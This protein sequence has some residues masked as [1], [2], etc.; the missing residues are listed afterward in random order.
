MIMKKNIVFLFS[1]LLV[2][3]VASSNHCLA[4]D[5]ITVPISSD[6]DINVE[7]FPATGKYLLLWLAPEYGWRPGHRSLSRRLSEQNIEVWLT[8]LLESLFLPQS[9]QAIKQLDG[10]YVADLIEYAHKKTGKKIIVAG[11]SY[12]AISA[13][14]GARQ[15]QQ[16]KQ[17]EHYLI[18]AV[19]FSP[20]TYAYIPSLGLAPEYMPIVSATNIPIM[21][22]QTEK[23]GTTGQF[24]VLLEKLQQHDNPVYVKF[25]PDVMSLFYNKKA[26][27]ELNNTIKDIPGNIKKMI[28]VLEKHEFP[29]EAI[30][31]KDFNINE[32]GIDVYLK[33]FKGNKT[34]L[35]IN[36]QDV[37]GNTV[38]KDDYKGKITVV[39]FWA[40]WC[41]PCVQE[42][43][44]LN[45]LK[46][47]MS[48]FP[49]ELISIN[50]A[51]DSQTILDFMKEVN[52]EFPVL[53]DPEGNFA[54]QWQVITYPSTFVIDT[55]GKIKYGVNAAIEWDDPEFIEKIKS[56]Y[57]TAIK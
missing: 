18:G 27:P 36:L 14:M 29:S 53:L 2:L 45:R 38:S 30:A 21:I 33:E 3:S 5:E 37:N 43:P 50:Y 20:Y 19:L 56:L 4:E 47:K 55:Q 6:I 40:T 54:K 16:R 25:I 52:V 11:D 42:I 26:T 13:L 48:D 9:S 8:N 15:W 49:F 22:Y 23:S 28:S 17:N 41:P 57:K 46:M 32:S 44:S 39:N 31:L 1:I 51:E 35:A 12:A 34:P 24:K 10:N 7:H